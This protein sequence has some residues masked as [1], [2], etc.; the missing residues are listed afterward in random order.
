MAY[1]DGLKEE[2]EK[3]RD[4]ID[5]IEDDK[6]ILPMEKIGPVNEGLEAEER[7]K[8]NNRIVAQQV[9]QNDT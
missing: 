6:I 8:Q 3:I 7:R 1:G 5:H 2:I 4:V 9:S